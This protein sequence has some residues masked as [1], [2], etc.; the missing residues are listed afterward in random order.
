M[1]NPPS[2][3]RS[4][5]PPPE[6]TLEDV[7]SAGAAAW[8]WAQEARRAWDLGPVSRQEPIEQNGRG[9]KGGEGEKDKRSGGQKAERARASGQKHESPPREACRP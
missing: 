4:E 1:F 6:A 2:A 7:E 9:E 8:R 5:D 3:A